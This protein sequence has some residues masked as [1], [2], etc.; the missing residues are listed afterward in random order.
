MDANLVMLS[1]GVS[2]NTHQLLPGQA[3]ETAL[4]I[5][6]WTLLRPGRA[7]SH[8]LPDGFILDISPAAA[9][10]WRE[11]AGAVFEGFL[12]TI[13]YGLTAEEL[14]APHR[15]QGTLRAYRK[16]QLQ[17]DLLADPGEQDLTAHVDFSAIQSAGEAEGLAT[18]Q[19]V[20]QER[21]LMGVAASFWSEAKPPQAEETRQFQTLVHPEHLGRAFKVLVQEKPPTGTD[22]KK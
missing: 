22:P 18:R 4:P 9:E 20:S 16:H 13:D 8:E 6:L 10:W 2:P 7:H 17:S 19:L 5:D 1:S 21:F 15:T 11:A 3:S 14:F 12:V